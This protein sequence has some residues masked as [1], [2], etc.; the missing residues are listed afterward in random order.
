[1]KLDQIAA[2]ARQSALGKAAKKTA[3][4]IELHQTVAVLAM[5]LLC[6]WMFWHREM[7]R[8]SQ[9]TSAKAS[10]DAVKDRHME[11]PEMRPITVAP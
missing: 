2:E 5:L 3:R 10:A 8:E 4:W 11:R 7:L 6:V 9:A 1:M